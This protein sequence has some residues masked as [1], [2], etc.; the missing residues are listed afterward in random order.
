MLIEIFAATSGATNKP[1]GSNQVI[2][3]Y[4]N[5]AG[6]YS[7]CVAGLNNG[8]SYEV[9]AS[10]PL[11]VYE[12]RAER[13]DV[14][15]NLTSVQ[16]IDLT[17]PLKLFVTLTPN[18]ITN[19]SPT[20]MIVKI[21]ST[22]SPSVTTMHATFDP[23]IGDQIVPFVG[24]DSTPGSPYNIWQKSVSIP[25]TL[26]ET[27]I[28]NPRWVSA[29]GVAGSN[30][31]VTTM[32][33]QPWVIDRTSP[34]IGG[35]GCGIGGTFRLF[36]SAANNPSTRST[37][38][39]PTVYIGVCD[40][41]AG[42]DLSSIQLTVDGTPR[43]VTVSGTAAFFNVY[44]SPGTPLS[45]GDHTFVYNIKD[46]A[47]NTQASAPL[48]IT[49]VD[50]GGS[51]PVISAPTPGP[52]HP[53]FGIPGPAFG[54]GFANTYPQISCYITDADGQ[55]DLVPGSLRV[56]LYYG[57]VEKAHYNPNEP[58][59]GNAANPNTGVWFQNTGLFNLK[60]NF[61]G[62][63]P[64]LYTVVAEISDHGANSTTYTW[65]FFYGFAA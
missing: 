14:H 43:F 59:G 44:F 60:Y 42:V 19:A 25:T 61:V 8:L 27:T 62:Q 31:L 29:Y 64:G 2:S 47:G 9:Q 36:G 15:T 7:L 22:A 18:A 65:Q 13:F 24:P 39:Q 63:L 48:K 23:P 32:D 26:S 3:T 16:Q 37:N 4:T 5:S 38:P 28:G 34:G 17:L 41:V 53:G 51:K 33:R 12:S 58:L 46:L 40:G 45:L 21:K 55:L 11:N 10:D 52:T 57:D 50:F 30:V 56:R 1:V 54:F 35:N 6:F 49:I 20:T